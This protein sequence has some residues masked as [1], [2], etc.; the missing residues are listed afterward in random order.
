[1]YRTDDGEP[2]VVFDDFGV[3]MFDE[4]ETFAPPADD[5]DEWPEPQEPVEPHPPCCTT[6]QFDAGYCVECQKEDAKP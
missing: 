1:M 6:G 4:A 3:Y 5:R 2:E